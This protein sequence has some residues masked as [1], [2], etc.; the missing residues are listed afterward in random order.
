MGLNETC[1]ASEH[2]IVDPK[3]K[4]LLLKSRNVSI[5]FII[6]SCL[7]KRFDF[8]DTCCRGGGEGGRCCGRLQYLNLYVNFRKMN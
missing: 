4:I 7:G 3:N 8:N 5:D 1:Y 2:S 6:G